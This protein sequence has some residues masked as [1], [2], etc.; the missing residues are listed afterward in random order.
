MKT[1]TPILI[2]MGMVV[3]A[4]AIWLATLIVIA[5]TPTDKLSYM[6]RITGN[7]VEMMKIIRLDKPQVPEDRNPE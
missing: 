3:T 6:E 4:L 7:G 2:G 5:N 1:Y